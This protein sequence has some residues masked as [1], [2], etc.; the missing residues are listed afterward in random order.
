M[1]HGGDEAME[2]D[3]NEASGKP[4]LSPMISTMFC[5]VYLVKSNVVSHLVCKVVQTFSFVVIY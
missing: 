5:V 2:D 3:T 4:E 1:H